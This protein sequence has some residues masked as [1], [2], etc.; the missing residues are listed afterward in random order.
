MAASKL[1]EEREGQQPKKWY[2]TTWGQIGLPVGGLAIY[3]LFGIV[4]WW[5]LD[6]YI[7]PSAFEDSK[8][9]T[10][11][12]DLIQALGFIMA[13]VAGAVGIFFTWR[14]L[15]QSQASLMLTQRTQEENQRS[16]QAQL[17]NAE[18]QLK[19]AQEELRLTRE[20]QITERFTRAIDQLGGERLE[21]RLGGIYAL[22][23]IAKD[24][25]ERDY[26]TVMEVL[27]AYVRENAPWPTKTSNKSPERSFIKPPEGDSVSDSSP[28]EAAEQDEGAE[29]QGV[30]P[31]SGSPRTDI[32]AILDVLNRREKNRAHQLQLQGT[33]LQGAA[34]LQ[35]AHL[36]GANLRATDL[37]EV[38]GGLAQ[39]QINPA[40][41]DKNTT[42]LPTGLHPP[43]HWS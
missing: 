36:S 22:E 7:D 11:K 42:K 2:E 30:E 6:H 31:T 16:T 3:L 8:K 41:G 29:Q 5:V 25:P 27:T 10:A 18:E 17:S 21:I 28:N 37:R 24:S 9:A 33:H 13:G 34:N 15:Q 1:P 32:Q 39:E 26:S 43:E 38:K 14:N 12:K 23:R 19:N 40:S 20:G 4:L 35:G